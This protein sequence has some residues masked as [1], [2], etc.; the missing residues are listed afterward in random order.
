MAERS[1]MSQQS[2]MR[3]R[4]TAKAPCANTMGLCPED[5]VPAHKG[6]SAFIAYWL[7]LALIGIMGISTP[8]YRAKREKV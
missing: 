8:N 6:S 3:R 2:V 1:T 4:I 5:S 7:S